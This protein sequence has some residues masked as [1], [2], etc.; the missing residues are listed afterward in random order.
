LNH[1]SDTGSSRLKRGIEQ[2]ERC[3]CSDAPAIHFARVVLRA[4]APGLSCHACEIALP[5]HIEAELNNRPGPGYRAIRHHLD[6]CPACTATYLALLET[7][8]I[9]EETSL[10]RPELPVDVSFLKRPSGRPTDAER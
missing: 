6:F 10:P 1:W 7:A 4:P 2:L 5:E 9:A 8:T 3:G